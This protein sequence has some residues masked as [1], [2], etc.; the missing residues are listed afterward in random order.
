M[1]PEPPQ[2]LN[3][4]YSNGEDTTA[5]VNN[6]AALWIENNRAAV[7]EWLQAARRGRRLSQNPA[8]TDPPH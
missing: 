3:V 7:D 8:G 6:H 1:D 2:L 4:D 5:D